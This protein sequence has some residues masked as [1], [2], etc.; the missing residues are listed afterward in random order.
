MLRAAGRGMRPGS[1]SESLV[2]C[3]PDL[4]AIT[5]EWKPDFVKMSRSPLS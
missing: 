4:L 1:R 5:R 3:S 2:Y